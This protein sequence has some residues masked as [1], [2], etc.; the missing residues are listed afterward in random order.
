MVR[1]YYICLYVLAEQ[2][3]VRAAV[4][5]C[6]AVE[7]ARTTT[8]GTARIVRRKR[9]RRLLAS[10][11]AFLTGSH[12][13]IFS[14][15]YYIFS[16][17]FFVYFCR[18]AWARCAIVSVLVVVCCLSLS[19]DGCAGQFFVAPPADVARI[20][21]TTRVIK[22]FVSVSVCVSVDT[23]ARTEQHANTVANTLTQPGPPAAIAV[24]VIVK[25]RACKSINIMCLCADGKI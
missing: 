4:V 6:D 17:F 12:N 23:F 5:R 1:I 2:P 22:S 7:C 9:T 10:V 14:I 11:C 3:A 15:K 21:P 8:N 24:V 25:Y 19:S 13:L 20:C 18:A 16:F